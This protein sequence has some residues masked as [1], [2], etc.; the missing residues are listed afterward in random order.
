LENCGAGLYYYSTAT[1]NATIEGNLIQNTTG[2]GLYIRLASGKNAVIND[3]V[4]INN[5]GLNSDGIYCNIVGDGGLVTMKNNSVINS[6]DDGIDL[7]GATNVTIANTIIDTTREY[8]LYAP[9]CNLSMINATIRGCGND[10]IYFAYGKSLTL[11]DSILENCGAGLYYYSTATENATIE[12]N[13][14][15][16]TTGNG[17]YIR[18]ASGKNAVINDNVIINNTG[19]NSDGIYCNIVGD[20]GLVTMKNNSVINSGDDG[21]DLSGA[22]NVTIANTIIDTTREYGLYA[23]RCNLSMINATIRGCGN[24]AIYFAYGKSLTLRDSVLENCGAGLYYYYTATGNATIEGN[25]IQNTTGNGLYI[26]LASGKSAVINDNMIVNSTGLNSDG[27]YCDIVGDGGLVTMKS[28]TVKNNGDDG[29]HISGAKYSTLVNNTISLN[30]G[31]G[32]GLYSSDSNL[33]FHNNLVDNSP[34][35][36]DSNPASNDWHHP[37]LLEGNYW[38]D[39][40]GVDDGSGTGK[41]AIAGDGI[42]DTNIPY[43]G[44]DYDYYPFVNESCWTRPKLNIIQAHTDKMAYGL[45][46]NVT[47]SC[48]V[49]NE[50]GV[51]ISVDNITTKIIKPD[52]STEWITLFEE[53]IGNYNGTFTNTSLF[54]TYNATIYAYKIGLLT[55]TAKLSFEVLPDHDI[56]VTNIDAP[57]STEINSIIIVNATISNTGLN[58]ESNITVDFIE[59]GISRSN[60]TIPFLESR[61]YTNVHFQWTAPGVAGRRHNIIIYAEHVVNETIVWNN[62]QSKIITIGDIW[63]PD[64]YP[65]I[66]QAV[67]NATAGDTIIVRDGAYTEN[68]DVNKCLRILAENESVLTIVQAAN[69][70]DHVFEVTADYVNISGFTVTGTD[71][72]GIYLYNV[73]RC[74][75]SDNKASDNGYG[76]YLNFSS[77]CTLTSNSANSNSGSGSYKRDGYGYGIYL[78][79][80]SNCTLTNNTANSNSG[81]GFYNYDGYGLGIYLVYSNNCTLTSNTANSNSG[82]GGYGHDPYESFG[83]VGEGYGIFLYSSSNCMLT[84]NTANSNN[85]IGGRGEN[86]DDWNEWGGGPGGDGYCNGIFLYSSSNCLLTNNTANS[87]MGSGGNGGRGQYGGFG[88]KGGDGYSSGIFLYSLSNCTLT[89]NTAY[90][91]IGRGG[92]GGNGIHDADGGDGG[93]GYGDGIYLSSSSNCTLI[94]NT[95]NSNYGSGGR[96]GSGGVGSGASDG[97]D[98]FGYGDGIFLYSSGNNLIYNNYFNNTNNAYDDGSNIWN[99]TKTSGTN[100]IGGPYLGGNYW[101]DY[102]GW[103]TNGD[104][105]GDIKLPYNSSGNIITGGDYLPLV[106]ILILQFEIK[107]ESGWNLI[108]LPLMPEDTSITSL[109]SPIN[110]NYSI[111]WEYNASNTSDHWK[112]YD[113]STP[114]GN[115]LTTMEPG[116]SYWIMMISYD[117]LNVS[118]TIPES[119]DIELWSGW[120]LI[121][122]NSLNPQTITDALSSINGN[123]NIVWAY[124]ASDSIDHWKKYDP[125]TPFGND[126]ANMEPGKGY[127][128][129]MTTDD[130]L[131]I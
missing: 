129:L 58:N 99:I 5:T 30:S 105:L 14:I 125:N 60:T 122:Y 66:Q 92:N 13:L 54:G 45:N 47:I 51:N 34:N 91:S 21:I 123:Y 103:D 130:I 101:S 53:L 68:V 22:T 23:P 96:G 10:A 98:G 120:N 79:F 110:G 128:I 83:G 50:T 104:G 111:V 81:T 44:L 114:F 49:Q 127:W 113:P 87:N 69:S 17:L 118:G 7:S 39:Y 126:L 46:E 59:D 117:I 82:I 78:N 48:I 26:R 32:I 61:S 57:S 6:G 43:P 89:N 115:D 80:S 64:N 84:N 108:S 67:N 76:I 100:I 97:N 119:T 36:Y 9:R 86:A 102:T 85:G 88:G 18:L 63:V 56:A 74:N 27:I 4:I 70:S 37:I 124:N 62:K 55:D 25:L 65:T 107:L 95:A 77:N 24:N 52:S 38:S 28:N 94:S 75:I 131:E 11:R 20:G 35:A 93:D 73:D 106:Q 16:N 1:E 33:L 41:H 40:T 2:N 116:K 42:G 15:Q 8:G 19:L 121:G 71:K 112:K 72:A 12:G 31:Y 29:I 3:N 90:S 109:L